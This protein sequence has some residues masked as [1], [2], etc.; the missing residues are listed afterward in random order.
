MAIWHD[1]RVRKHQREP[2]RKGKGKK[3]DFIIKTYQLLLSTASPNPGVSTTVNV[4]LTP[5]SFKRVW[6]CS[7]YSKENQGKQCSRWNFSF[8]KKKENNKGRKTIR[9][10]ERRSAGLDTTQDKVWYVTYL[11]RLFDTVR[12]TR[13]LWWINI[14]QKHGIDERRL[15]QSWLADDH[16][17][18]LEAFFDSPPVHLV[19]K[20]IK[21]KERKRQK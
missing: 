20:T 21:K 18:K 5:F 6:H 15:S 11:N 13:I 14:G 10:K 4:K 19:G 1:E 8:N 16:Q 3:K 2:K 17:R 7:T 12:R 9:R